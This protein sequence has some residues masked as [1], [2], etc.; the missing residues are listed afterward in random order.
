M[1]NGFSIEK[2]K[3]T[4]RKHYICDQKINNM[5]DF[6][7]QVSNDDFS[8]GPLNITTNIWVYI[9]IYELYL[10][11]MYINLFALLV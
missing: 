2:K 8:W 9:C 1:F 7:E 3:T 10:S 6:L 11:V 5:T 4:E